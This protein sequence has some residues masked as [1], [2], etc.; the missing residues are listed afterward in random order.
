MLPIAGA[1]YSADPWQEQLIKAGLGLVAVS[2]TLACCL[3]LYGIRQTPKK[4]TG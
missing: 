2:I 1:G 4:S 3:A